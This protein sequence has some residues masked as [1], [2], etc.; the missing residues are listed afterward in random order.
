MKSLS[1]L[2]PWAV[3]IGLIAFIIITN[4]IKA[5]SAAFGNL[6]LALY[7]TVTIPFLLILLFLESTF[8]YC[9]F[10]WIAG[11]GEYVEMIRVKAATYL[12]TVISFLVGLGGLVI[13]AKRRYGISYTLGTNIMLNELLHEVATQGSLA[14]IACLLLPS[15]LVPDNARN[16]VETVMLAGIIGIGFYLLCILTSRIFRYL[17]PRYRIIKVFNAF[18]DITLR[19]YAAFFTIKIVQ[20]IFYGLFLAGMLYSFGIRPPLIAV[21]AFMQII[22]FVRSIPVTAFGIGI[23]QI[24]VPVLFSAW[25][26][27]GAVPAG[28]GGHLLA[29][30]IIF[31]FT[32]FVG[33]AMLGIPFV[34][35]VFKDIVEQ[36]GQG[37]GE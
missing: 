32:L 37:Q 19:Q 1:G 12:L 26:P 17:P 11:V 2:I 16:Q 18:I 20:N 28:A 31:T 29:C 8:L 14:A 5:I 13:Y 10:K 27:V 34:S 21:I 15:S 9:G 24:A 6:N 7:F 22:Q 35:G 3:S 36:K 30:S 4:D 23:D 25:A 33:R